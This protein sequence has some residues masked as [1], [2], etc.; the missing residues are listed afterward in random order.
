MFVGPFSLE[1]DRD[2]E[3]IKACYNKLATLVLIKITMQ[4]GG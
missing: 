2:L 3:N 4:R 1:Q